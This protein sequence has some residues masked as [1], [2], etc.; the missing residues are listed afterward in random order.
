MTTTNSEPKITE[1]GLP[2][3]RHIDAA[4][5]E[6]DRAAKALAKLDTAG[7]VAARDV[8]KPF[9]K[10]TTV[11]RAAKKILDADKP[12]GKKKT[13]KTSK[14]DPHHKLRQAIIKYATAVNAW[15]RKLLDQTSKA[16]QAADPSVMMAL[17]LFSELPALSNLLKLADA[18]DLE[19]IGNELRKAKWKVRLFQHHDPSVVAAE[20]KKSGKKRTTKKRSSKGASS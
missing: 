1:A 9:V 5:Q 14:N 18:G 17:K 12:G 15:S 13:S 20:L 19:T 3:I 7:V 10:P 11:A 6:R 16:G 2:D 4:G 8:A